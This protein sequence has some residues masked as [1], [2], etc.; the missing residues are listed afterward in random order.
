MSVFTSLLN[1]DFAHFRRR[2]S[3][4]GQG[5]WPLDYPPE[6]ATTIRGRIRPALSREREVAASEERLVTHVFYCEASADV[7]RGDRL[8][9][10]SP[11][12]GYLLIVEVD[13]L[14]EPSL[15]GEHLEFDCNEKQKEVAA[16]VGS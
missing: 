12:S 5:G 4:D 9:C 3:P 6:G 16:E 8:Q 1:N 13:A 7:R 11:V 14:R 2:R 15:A 10:L